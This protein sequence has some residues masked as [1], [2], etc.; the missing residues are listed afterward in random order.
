MLKIHFMYRHETLEPTVKPVIIYFH[1]GSYIWGDNKY[2]DFGPEL[3]MDHDV[4]F[5][6]VNY[7]YLDILLTSS[8]IL[9]VYYIILNCTIFRLGPFGFLSLGTTDCPGNQGL[10]DQAKAL[11]WVA[12]HIEYFGGDPDNITIMG[13]SAGS[14]SVFYHLF[15]PL[16]NGLFKKAMLLSG[17]L[18]YFRSYR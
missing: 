1:G 13:E 4:I 9:M 16:S 3:F 10:R 6:N 15:T 17:T 12:D 2:K 8:N 11:Q 18:D 7:R 5:V 14:W